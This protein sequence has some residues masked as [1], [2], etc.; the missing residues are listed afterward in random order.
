MFW[1]HADTATYWLTTARLAAI[2]HRHIPKAHPA[3]DSSSP[4]R[5]EAQR[6]DSGITGH[7]L[8]KLERILMRAFQVAADAACLSG[9]L[10]T[11]LA[12]SPDSGPVSA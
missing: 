3:T 4:T 9:E 5:P 10:P 12:G 2:W 1:D 6:P 11:A 8:G 7:C